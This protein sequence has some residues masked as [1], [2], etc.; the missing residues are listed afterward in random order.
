MLDMIVAQSSNENSIVLD[1]FAGSGGVGV[2]AS[3]LNRHF[4]LVDESDEAIKVIKKRLG[5]SLFSNFEM[6]DLIKE[7]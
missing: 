5:E 4:I 7:K 2:A 6:I 1:C 3:N